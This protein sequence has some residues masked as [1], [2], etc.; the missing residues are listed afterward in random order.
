M[1]NKNWNIIYDGSIQAN[2][3]LKKIKFGIGAV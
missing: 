3:A 1:K 2:P